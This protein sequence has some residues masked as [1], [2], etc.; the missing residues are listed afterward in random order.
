MPGAGG[1]AP[2]RRGQP[3]RGPGEAVSLGHLLPR[4]GAAPPGRGVQA[5]ADGLRHVQEAPSH[6]DRA[7]QVLLGGRGLLPGLFKHNPLRYRYYHHGSGRD[8]FLER[9]WGHDKDKLPPPPR[10][11]P[12]VKPSQAEP[13]AKLTP[14]QYEVTQEEGTEPPFKNE[15]N[16]NKRAGIY[17][18]IVSS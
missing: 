3:V 13:K 8:Q 14:L 6:L 15:Y 5:E 9:T 7:L 18:D 17:V 2:G 10:A 4:R 16:D 11:R 1:P 12:F